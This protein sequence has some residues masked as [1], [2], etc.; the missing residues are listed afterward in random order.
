MFYQMSI[1]LL[2]DTMTKI[3]NDMQTACILIDYEYT[4]VAD[5]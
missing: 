5:S 4:F 2:K 1:S 3:D